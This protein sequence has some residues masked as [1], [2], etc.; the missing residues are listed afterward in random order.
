LFR[1]IDV[2]RYLMVPRRDAAAL[3]EGT[4]WRLL[5]QWFPDVYAR[6]SVGDTRDD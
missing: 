4:A 1:V 5:E 6:Y 3:P 2:L